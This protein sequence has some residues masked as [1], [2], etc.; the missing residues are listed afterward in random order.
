MRKGSMNH[1]TIQHPQGN[2]FADTIHKPKKDINLFEHERLNKLNSKFMN[3]S[4][5]IFTKMNQQK[6][7]PEGK[8][9][10]LDKVNRSDDQN[11]YI[12]ETDPQKKA[13]LIFGR[14]TQD[15]PNLSKIQY[16]PP[17]VVK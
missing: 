17:P 2:Y 1:T 12:V 11:M 4:T 3:Q 13:A 16:A 7:L 15:F 9:L 14:N 5:N 6:F 8:K 10:Y